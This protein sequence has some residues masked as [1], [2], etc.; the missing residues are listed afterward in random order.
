VKHIGPEQAAEVLVTRDRD[1][2]Y[3]PV[4]EETL[5]AAG[6][7]PC[8]QLLRDSRDG[9]I[10]THD[11]LHPNP[12]SEGANFPEKTATQALFSQ[13]TACMARQDC[14]DSTGFRDIQ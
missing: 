2:I 8:R 14:R 12:L 7:V 3:T 13:L 4:F 11:L 9:G 5:K 6:A 10:Y 1:V